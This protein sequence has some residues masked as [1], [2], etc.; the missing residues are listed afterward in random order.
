MVPYDAGDH[1]LANFSIIHS[2]IAPTLPTSLKL[3]VPS[4]SV[5]VFFLD[6]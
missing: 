2:Y 3:I 4:Y 5:L 1:F 6:I